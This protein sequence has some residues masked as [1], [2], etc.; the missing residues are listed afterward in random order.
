MI[1]VSDAT[2]TFD[3]LV[4][5]EAKHRP[6][7]FDPSVHNRLCISRNTK[8]FCIYAYVDED[9][10][11]GIV[12][13]GPRTPGYLAHSTPPRYRECWKP[14]LRKT[15]SPNDGAHDIFLHQLSSSTNRHSILKIHVRPFSN[16]PTVNSIARK[17]YCQT[18]DL[19]ASQSRQSR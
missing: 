4:T 11:P 16:R 12:V 8:M 1:T 5:R 17:F 9:D 10:E 13:I 14:L 3:Q 7:C 18:I 6:L 19:A 15:S 2:K